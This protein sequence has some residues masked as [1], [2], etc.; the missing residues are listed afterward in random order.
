LAHG[1]ARGVIAQ[2]THTMHRQTLDQFALAALLVIVVPEDGVHA[3]ASLQLTQ[4]M[5]QLEGFLEAT[6]MK[7]T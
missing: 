4:V 7:L 6:D 1:D 3:I 2:K 5:N